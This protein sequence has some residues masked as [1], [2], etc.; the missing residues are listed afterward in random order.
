MRGP[1]RRVLTTGCAL[2]EGPLWDAARACL[3]FVDI[4]QQSLWRYDPARHDCQPFA[5]P[6]QIGWV[7]PATGDQL[8]AGLQDGL[9]RFDVAYARW[10]KL[11]HIPGEQATNRLNDACV[12]AA[13]GAWFGSMD[14]GEAA[15]SGRFYRYFRGEV[16]PVGP[17]GICITNGPAIN[18][19]GTRVYFTDTLAR[20][21]LQADIGADGAVSPATLF[22]DTARDFPDA[23]PDGPVCDA[24]GCVWTGL[25]NGW[26]V[27]RYAPDGQLLGKVTLPVAN[28]TKMAFGGPDLRTAFVTTARKG[29][30]DEE[31][32]R[33]PLAGDLF[34]FDAEVAGVAR[35]LVELSV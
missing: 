6:G 19:A 24:E 2:G 23:Y 5:A 13:G 35:P 31:L 26:G 27:A 9:W 30:S 14:D 8:L 20:R 21:I 4:K 18:A 22:A 12:D 15:A 3:W 16:A 11:S 1:V 28:V 32:L 17:D 33:Q 29:L 7:L 25:W 34:S 10:H